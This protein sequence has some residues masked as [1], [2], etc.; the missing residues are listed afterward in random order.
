MRFF[1]D[2]AAIRWTTCSCRGAVPSTFRSRSSTP[3]R[4]VRGVEQ[5]VLLH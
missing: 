3:A 4:F 5:I 1:A 2:L